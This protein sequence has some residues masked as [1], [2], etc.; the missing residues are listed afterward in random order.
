MC[1]WIFDFNFSERCH[2]LYNI[3]RNEGW[4]GN[5]KGNTQHGA[6]TSNG[7]QLKMVI[8][9]CCQKMSCFS[10]HSL[11]TIKLTQLLE[12]EHPRLRCGNIHESIVSACVSFF[13]LF[14]WFFCLVD[15]DTL[16]CRD[17]GIAWT[18]NP[19][20]TTLNNTRMA[21]NCYY[22]RSQVSLIELNPLEFRNLFP[23]PGN[24]LNLA[25]FVIMSLNPLETM[26][27][28]RHS[29]NLLS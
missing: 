28:I 11:Q 23:R 4:Q 19:T 6:A 3:R 2:N 15:I 8:H 18:D 25:V 16:S 29:S 17:A 5:N 27:S 9:R 7:R 24:S 1:Y 20:T 22:Q 10:S 13:Y 21:P 26:R 14:A 12:R